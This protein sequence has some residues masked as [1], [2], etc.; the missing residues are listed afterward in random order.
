MKESDGRGT[1]IGW[2]G[3]ALRGDLRMPWGCLGRSVLGGG[4]V[5][6]WALR[7]GSEVCEEQP[8]DCYGC[9]GDNMRFVQGAT[10]T[11]EVFG[12]GGV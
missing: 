10:G 7:E 5:G 6:A 2:L 12:R 4:K 1:Q 11:L 9:C 8:G 3:A